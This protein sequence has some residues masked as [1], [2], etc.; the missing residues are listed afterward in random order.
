VGFQQ[1]TQNPSLREIIPHL[2]PA[3]A[4]FFTLL[5]A[6]LDKV[7]SFYL[8]REKEY[9]ARSG[10]L[11]DQLRELEEHRRLFHV[12]LLVLFLFAFPVFNAPVPVHRRLLIPVGLEQWTAG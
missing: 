4:A 11:E 9:R 6:E 8:R 7:E 2:S 12:R 10:V 5:D 3:E 1:P